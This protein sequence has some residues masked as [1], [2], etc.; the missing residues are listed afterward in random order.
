MV[1]ACG[2]GF[3][4]FLSV[5]WAAAS[6]DNVSII[7]Q[8]QFDFSIYI[9]IHAYIQY[10][11]WLWLLHQRAINHFYVAC[12]CIYIKFSQSVFI[13]HTPHPHLYMCSYVFTEFLGFFFASF[14]FF[15]YSL[16]NFESLLTTIYIIHTST[17][18]RIDLDRC[19]V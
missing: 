10:S 17:Y 11:L 8:L 9:Y 3:T 19:D 2:I 4:I 14:I 5:N 13:S 18:T 1:C 16:H 12:V 6:L 15:L 7:Q